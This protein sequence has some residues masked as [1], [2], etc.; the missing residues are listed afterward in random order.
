VLK[1]DPSK[2]NIVLYV[3]NPVKPISYKSND[4]SAG[5][6]MRPRQKIFHHPISPEGEMRRLATRIRQKNAFP[7]AQ[8]VL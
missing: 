2:N 6:R 4:F 1:K 8:T 7:P 3:R 5:G